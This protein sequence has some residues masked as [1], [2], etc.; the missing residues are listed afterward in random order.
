MGEK[1]IGTF[2]GLQTDIEKF[3]DKSTGEIPQ[4]AVDKKWRSKGIG[5]SILADLIEHTDAGQIK[6]LNID[7]RSKQMLSFIS[8]AGFYHTVNQFEM[9]LNL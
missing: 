6:I 9:K 2:S 3:Y 4:I 5:S 1:K 7:T 8:A